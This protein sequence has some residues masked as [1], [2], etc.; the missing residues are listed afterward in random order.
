MDGIQ[1]RDRMTPRAFAAGFCIVLL[2]FWFPAAASA[3]PGLD[4]AYGHGGIAM[5]P[6]GVAGV[7]PDVELTV[8]RGGSAVVA[9][10][11]EGTAVRFGAGGSRDLRFGKGG[12][13]VVRPGSSIG[14]PAKVFYP[15]SITV[16]HHGRVL[17]FGEQ[18]DESQSAVGPEQIPIS[19]GLAMV[20]RFN[21]DGRRDPS[22]GEG[23][24]YVAGGFGLPPE[25]TTGLLR[26]G[27]L[28]GRVD[29]RDRPLF[30][31][32]TT[33]V[34]GG[35]QGHGTI[36]KVPGALVRLTPAGRPDPDF[37]DG[38]GVS[39]VVGSGRSP[40]LAVD[41]ADQPVLG[42]GRV[43][44]YAAACGAGTAVYRFGEEGEPMAA[45]GS[46]GIREFPS[47]KLGL[48]EPSG[49]MILD[50]SSGRTLKL[51]RVGPKGNDVTGFGKGGVARLRSPVGVG[52]H[53]RPAGVDAEGRIVLAGF[54]GSPISEP[55]K[56]QRRSSFVVARVLPDGKIDRSFGD[57]GWIFSRLPNPLEL[58]STQASLDPDGRLLI[59]GMVTKPHH[60]DGAFTV[61]R[62]LLGS[63][64]ASAR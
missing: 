55:T 3:R 63:S 54:V 4:P 2:A 46:A 60:L 58:I 40:E 28:A 6:F 21:A 35:C 27:A 41:A 61:A 25:E 1:S 37:G 50:E 5:T 52:L 12:K 47:V 38:D 10:G 24:G 36:G 11:I 31:V 51:V 29:S 59:A 56:G 49:G 43:G 32:G 57:H 48:V 26:T 53:L 20:V 15:S 23:H 13:I 7:E 45:F 8:A 34:V 62:Y 30:V 19:P 64:Q 18:V 44:S 33:T 14:G 22:F 17:A 42:V 39:P 9:D 16:D